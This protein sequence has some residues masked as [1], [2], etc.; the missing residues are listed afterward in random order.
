MRD[1]ELLRLALSGDQTAGE[2]LAEIY[3]SK[4][5]HLL[6]VCLG[7]GARPAFECMVSSLAGVKGEFKLELWRVVLKSTDT[8]GNKLKDLQ[9]RERESL[10]LVLFAG[11]PI[12]EVALVLEVSA[13]EVERELG[14]ALRKVAVGLPEQVLEI[15]QEC[16]KARFFLPQVL[17]GRVDEE[18]G[19]A[20]HLYACPDCEVFVEAVQKGLD[21]LKLPSP[22]DEESE[23]AERSFADGLV[24]RERRA[25]QGRTA[26]FVFIVLCL[27]SVVW[28]W[29]RER[30]GDRVVPPPIRKPPRKVYLLA[31]YGESVMM[32]EYRG[33]LALPSVE[34]LEVK[35]Y[36]MEEG[37]LPQEASSPKEA[38]DVKLPSS[39][40]YS[41]VQTVDER[42]EAVEGAIVQWD[43]WKGFSIS[44]RFGYARVPESAGKLI[45]IRA[46]YLPREASSR[47]ETV[48]LVPAP[49]VSG[50]LIEESTGACV[51]GAIVAS[52]DGRLGYIA[53]TRKGGRFEVSLP[54]EGRCRLTA[55]CPGY[56][57]VWREVSGGEEVVLVLTRE[58]IYR[59]RVVDE[60]TGKG[61]GRLPLRVVLQSGKKVQLKT[62]EEG[63]F[64]YRSKEPGA[65]LLIE[66]GRR[67]YLIPSEPFWVLRQKVGV[68]ET[69]IRVRRGVALRVRTPPG[70][71]GGRL[72]VE[73]LVLSGRPE[74]GGVYFP[75]VPEGEGWLSVQGEF[76]RL[77]LV[78]T[79]EVR[80][81]SLPAVP[82]GEVVMR[83][84]V[85]RHGSSELSGAERVR[86]PTGVWELGVQ[87]SE[88]LIRWLCTRLVLPYEEVVLETP[89]RQPAGLEEFSGTVR[90]QD[91]S[92]LNGVKVS[93]RWNGWERRVLTGTRGKF[94]LEAG[95]R[96]VLTIISPGYRTVT[97]RRGEGIEL[98][99]RESRPPRS[100]VSG[101]GIPESFRVCG[102]SGRRVVFDYFRFGN[103]RFEL[104]SPCEEV[105]VIAKGFRWAKSPPGTLQ[106][107]RAER[108]EGT[109]TTEDGNLP[110]KCWAVV[111]SGVVESVPVEYG[112]FGIESYPE[113]GK[114]LVGAK[115]FAPAV[116]ELPLRR[117]Q[118]IKVVLKRGSK[119]VIRAPE[120]SAITVQ[121]ESVPEL[122]WLRRTHGESVEINSPPTGRYKV[123]LGYPPS[124][125]TTHSDYGRRVDLT[126]RVEEGGRLEVS[127]PTK[128]LIIVK[129]GEWVIRGKLAKREI[130]FHSLPPGKFRVLLI[131]RGEI[132]LTSEVVLSPK[133][134]KRVELMRR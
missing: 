55:L 24:K 96:A 108:I 86:V 76:P 131:R 70:V 60:D 95:K 79:E 64:E 111:L 2:A 80:E 10:L 27:V 119:L 73:G 21:S 18:H 23:W 99:L 90:A 101:E 72:R 31:R 26:V 74:P 62:S 123:S 130:R 19:E 67:G 125:L 51:G 41:R 53:L 100:S 129:K 75:A 91:G 8:P 25:F 45:V 49:V 105:M 69:I 78:E 117:S 106:L 5:F 77:A 34:G 93:A 59:G 57:P 126:Q 94:S 88:N 65:E 120:G 39:A 112:K 122:V 46:P 97:E 128:G 127:L 83:G 98:S 63:R 7:D 52:S 38:L 33:R 121:S 30:L 13:D 44:D 1:E 48:R 134:E 36:A 11:L 50:K 84:I 20:V 102:F 47:D 12:E 118:P 89:P 4:A 87:V 116:V 16:E 42:G 37:H 28:M 32:R 107:Q 22:T 124:E 81:L 61:V 109:V 103:K 9:K 104:F 82:T 40:G 92:P 132:V 66:L 115:G 68:G 58:F 71:S 3:A 14:S 15:P 113:E 35:L 54:S 85:A 56:P 43:G 17:F 110:E 133:E 29:R 6:R 114:L